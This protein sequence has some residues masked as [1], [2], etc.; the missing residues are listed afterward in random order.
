MHFSYVSEFTL[1]F[2]DKFTSLET[3]SIISHYLK[4]FLVKGKVKYIK[5][6]L[7]NDFSN[8]ITNLYTSQNNAMGE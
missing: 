1:I 8:E 3:Y 5:M 4:L 6:K 2:W 7:L